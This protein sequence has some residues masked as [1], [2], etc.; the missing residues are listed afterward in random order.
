M[1]DGRAVFQ[2]QRSAGRKG[3]VEA[4]TFD[5]GAEE[6]GTGTGFHEEIYLHNG[7]RLTIFSGKNQGWAGCVVFRK[8]IHHAQCTGFSGSGELE[9]VRQTLQDLF[10]R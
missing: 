6:E 7:I 3:T 9:T 5:G 1:I 10:G 4:G 2:P 8:Y